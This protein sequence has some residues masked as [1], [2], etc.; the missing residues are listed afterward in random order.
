MGEY[1]PK[2]Q[3][4]P[5]YIYP[6]RDTVGVQL[7]NNPNPNPNPYPYPYPHRY[8][9]VYP[10]TDPN[11]NPHPHPTLIFLISSWGHVPRGETDLSKK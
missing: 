4:W 3:R 11:P 8:V 10:N 1:S 9:Y 5:T 2:D 7:P 6:R